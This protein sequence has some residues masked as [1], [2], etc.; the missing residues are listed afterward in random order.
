MHY[1]KHSIISLIF[2]L[3]FTI[4]S[5]AQQKNFI[6]D[7]LGINKLTIEND[8]FNLVWSSNPSEIYFKQEYLKTNEKLEK[9]SKM[10]TIDVI[11]GIYNLEDVV[12]IKISELEKLK[13]KNPIINYQK[14]TKDD[15]I[16][17]DFLISENSPDG[18]EIKVIERNVY[19]YK[20]TYDNNGKNIILL[21]AMSERAYEDEIDS[22][23]TNLK[24]NKNQLLNI[25]GNFQIPV[26]TLTK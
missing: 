26:V 3:L 21:F 11:N 25:I 14:F 15:E 9:F 7:Y 1:I 20:S 10:I 24:E 22:F 16:M 6:K 8:I 23:F 4:N 19:R 13:E 12:K 17:L 5:N 18:K 2:S